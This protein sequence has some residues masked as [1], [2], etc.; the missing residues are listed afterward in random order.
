MTQSCSGGP[1]GSIWPNHKEL[2]RVRRG[3]CGLKTRGCSNMPVKLLAKPLMTCLQ[4]IKILQTQWVNF[5]SLISIKSFYCRLQEKRT[6]I[7]KWKTRKC[8]LTS[9]LV[10]LRWVGLPWCCAQ[11]WFPGQ[12]RTS[13]VY[14][15]MKRVM[16]FKAPRSTESFQTLYACTL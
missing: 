6:K 13:G 16:G 1:Y 7:R 3:L 12:Q 15:P 5:S 2:R 8:T 11:T 4:T 9:G 14:A 10:R